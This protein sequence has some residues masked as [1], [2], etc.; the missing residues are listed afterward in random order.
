[1]IPITNAII[2]PGTTSNP[3]TMV[4]E[5]EPRNLRFYNI[6]EF[7]EPALSSKSSVHQWSDAQTAA[8]SVW[9]L[10]RAA[11]TGNTPIMAATTATGPTVEYTTDGG[12]TWVK[13]LD[14][15]IRGN[16]ANITHA[17]FYARCSQAAGQY[18]AIASY[19][20]GDYWVEEGPTRARRRI[21]EANPFDV[22]ETDNVFQS[23]TVDPEKGE[24]N[25]KQSTPMMGQQAPEISGNSVAMSSV[26]GVS[27]TKVAIEEEIW[28]PLN[29]ANLVSTTPKWFSMKIA[30][31]NFGLEG[32]TASTPILSHAQVE[33][34]RHVWWGPT[35]RQGKNRICSFKLTSAANAFQNARLVIA[36][37]PPGE[38]IPTTVVGLTQYP[39]V[40]HN[41][42]GP[43]T[44]FEAQWQIRY[45]VARVT[46]TTADDYSGSLVI[47]ML[48]NSL[49]TASTS[50]APQLTLWVNRAGI[51]FSLPCAPRTLTA[52]A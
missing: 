12:V 30:P 21:R 35:R 32:S 50:T 28:I 27:E 17:E 34:A 5:G 26:V 19:E 2:F 18:T 47:W 20:A 37:V 46:G 15:T 8:G 41:L 7:I 33:A 49:S 52:F 14:G 6:K 16:L 51:E 48:E 22:D 44:V 25:V 13:F 10:I 40:Y 24:T 4:I 45:P 23:G 9:H 31:A 29:T 39:H 1:V 11:P 36:Q 3:Q 42:H 38:A 43:D